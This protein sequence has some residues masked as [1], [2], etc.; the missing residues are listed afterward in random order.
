MCH[1]KLGR[2]TRLC[3]LGH[4]ARHINKNNRQTK[5]RAGKASPS[6]SYHEKTK[7]KHYLALIKKEKYVGVI[8]DTYNNNTGIY[9]VKTRIT[10]NRGSKVLSHQNQTKKKNKKTERCFVRQLDEVQGATRC[11]SVKVYLFLLLVNLILWAKHVRL[12]VVSHWL[13]FIFK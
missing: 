1:Q 10:Y 7:N 5:M 12:F 2:C 8:L 11:R 13:G 9:V 6:T 3:K 4:C